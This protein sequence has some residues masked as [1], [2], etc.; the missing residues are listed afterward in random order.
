MG[1]FSIFFQDAVLLNNTAFIL[2]LIVTNI[3]LIVLMY[4]CSLYW[5]T[6]KLKNVPR[7][8]WLLLSLP[9]TTVVLILNVNDFVKA[10]ININ[11]LF[12]IILGLLFSNIACIYIYYKTVITISKEKELIETLDKTK[13]EYEIASD[14]L[15]QHNVF[16][17][18]IRNHSKEM[19]DLLKCEKYDELENY[20]NN[21]YGESTNT[22]NM[23]NTNFK[24]LDVLI[25]DR[26]YIIKTNNILLRTKL[27][28]IDFNSINMID[29]EN[30]FKFFV[31]LGINECIKSNLEQP[32][33][34]I[35]SKQIKEQTIVIFKFSSKSNDIEERVNQEIN[36]TLEKHNTY[37]LVENN[38]DDSEVNITIVFMKNCE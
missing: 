5:K 33:L 12:I 35:K 6:L 3:V 10:I 13:L 29:I 17:H 28:S 30:I 26:I 7:N 21:V 11:V 36:F 32:Y 20:I 23:I 1:I 31:D 24:I 14:L 27:E 37:Y 18:D 15:S 2:G 8:S 4:I 16:L 25:N 19:L 9:I 34:Y 22:F 38:N